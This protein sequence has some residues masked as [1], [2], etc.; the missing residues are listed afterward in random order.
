MNIN[1]FCFISQIA[2]DAIL[3]TH[4]G[5]ESVAF[6][7]ISVNKVVL[8][9]LKLELFHSWILKQMFSPLKLY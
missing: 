4:N 9:L 1:T 8:I 7:E 6:A 3:S 5:D 2:L